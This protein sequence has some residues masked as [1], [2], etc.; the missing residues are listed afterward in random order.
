MMAGKKQYGKVSFKLLLLAVYF[1]F[2]VVQSFLRFTSPQSR[3]SLETDN[4]QKTFTGKSCDSKN[5]LSQ[6]NLGKN[7]SLTYLNKRFHPKHAVIIPS[8]DFELRNF[9]AN[10]FVKPYFRDEYIADIKINSI[11]LRG[12]PS[13]I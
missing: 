5:I 6:N 12:P 1:V 10:G 8:N 4:Y 13:L 3:Q 2:F 7:K 11:S 9:Y